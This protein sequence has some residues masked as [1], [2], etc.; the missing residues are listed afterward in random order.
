M[1]LGTIMF[2]IL[3][4]YLSFIFTIF[5]IS[6][7]KQQH[8]D[9]FTPPASV[10]IPTYNE[11][12]NIID[13]LQAVFSSSYPEFEVIVVD[14]GSND[15]TVEIAQLFPIKVI[16]RNHEGKTA[17]LNAGCKAARHNNLFVIDAD[18][19]I[20]KDCMRNIIEPLQDE[21]VAATS[22]SC[23]VANKHNALT[24]FQNIEYHY[25]NLI[26]HSFSTVFNTGIWFF[27]AMA[28][29]KKDALEQV[30]FFKQD[31]LAEDTDTAL[32][33][34]GVG[35]R[36]VNVHNAHG[37]TVVPET[38]KGLFRQRQR[39]WIGVLQS[40]RKNKKLFSH[41]SSPSILFLFVNQYWWTLYAFLSFP[42]ILYQVW[43][44]LPQTGMEIASY[45][46]RW[47]SAVGPFYVL[48][49]IPEWGLNVYNIFGVMSGVISLFLIAFA[50]RLFKDKYTIG[51][52]LA[53]FFYF[54]Y[55]I[56]LN[57]LICI[58]MVSKKGKYFIK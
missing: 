52:T 43:Y 50:I 53:T 32:E 27:G 56:F 21:Q 17:A 33:L 7:F 8:F 31:T 30:G 10:I 9:S 11:E 49:K 47:F 39:W 40:L 54:P 46:F 20:A 23:H 13:C 37:F 19:H 34:H 57:S 38:M 36:T 58:S 26:R 18:T 45:L 41:Q 6:R 12:K 2:F 55:T 24:I 44:W 29:Y 22:G 5:V 25:N 35:Y 1:Q 3:F 4:G 42:I 16:Q 28:A 51:N 14:D 48:Y 15:R